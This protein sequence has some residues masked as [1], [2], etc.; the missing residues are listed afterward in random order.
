MRPRWPRLE[1][2]EG[3][4][5]WHRTLTGPPNMSRP[6]EE[7]RQGS[8]TALTSRIRRGQR[9]GDGPDSPTR[10]KWGRKFLNSEREDR[11]GTQMPR[12]PQQKLPDLRSRDDPGT[13]S[14]LRRRK[15]AGDPGAQ[16]PRRLQ[17]NIPN[18]RSEESLD[19][20][21]PRIP[22]N[23]LLGREN[24]D[25]PGSPT[26]P[27]PGLPNRVP[28]QKNPTIQ[29]H[30]T[31]PLPTNQKHTTPSSP[32]NN[33]RF[34][35]QL[36]PQPG[37]PSSPL[38]SPSPAKSSTSPS[39]PS[40]SPLYPDPA[41]TSPPLPSVPPR[42]VSPA[43]YPRASPSRQPPRPPSKPP[44]SRKSRARTGARLSWTLKR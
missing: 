44:K 31:P 29:P 20:Q 39:A 8:R 26:L 32:P 1:G 14:N 4:R 16:T 23:N 17:K 28:Q 40:C 6:E 21:T 38:L 43:S 10:R 33:V 25:G 7:D 35:F 42:N 2:S 9:L 5:E 19:T 11:T 36:S 12:M 3:R 22:Q 37:R 41:A 15:N 13:Q 18:L 27:T 34:P 30:Q 24:E